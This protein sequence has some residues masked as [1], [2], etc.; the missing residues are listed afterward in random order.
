MSDSVSNQRE[1]LNGW[2]EFIFHTHE[3]EGEAKQD[4]PSRH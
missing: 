3:F 1:N 2:T 4:L